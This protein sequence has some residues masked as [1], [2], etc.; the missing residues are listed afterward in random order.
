[1]V[2]LPLAW[3]VAGLSRERVVI[4][5]DF[6]QIPPIIQS[7]Q[8]AIVQTVGLDAF[9]A[10]QIEVDDQRL[11]HL[12]L[13]YR[14]DP[15]ICDLISGPMYSHRLTTAAGRDVQDCIVS[16]V[17]VPT[18]FD[19]VLTVID[20]SDLWP[21]ETQTA[22]FSR[23]NLM[24]ALLAR[25][26]AWHLREHGAISSKLDLGI[27]TPYAAQAKLIQ[28]LTQGEL[29]DNYVQVGTVHRFQGDERRMMLLDIPES[30]GGAPYPGRLIQGIPQEQE[31]AR[32]INVAVSRAQCRLF[33][34]ANLT[35]LDKKLPSGS[36]LRSI[37]FDMQEHGH[38]VSGVELLALRPIESDLAG[39][40]H[41]LP[42]EQITET[43]GIFDEAAFERAIRHDISMAKESV[44]IYS[45]YVTPSRAGQL[46]DLFRSKILE[47]VSVRCV[48][49]PP[50]TNGS[51]PR[52]LGREALDMLE[53]IGVTVDC[54]AKI[55]QKV[56]LIDNRIVWQGSL[57]ALSH[58]GRAD[59]TM[60]R[61]V[62][63]GYGAALAA[64]MSKRRMSE[65]KAAAA[66]AQAENP[67]C[68]VCGSRTIYH[69]GKHGPYYTCESECGW[70]GNQR[71]LD[72]GADWE[73]TERSSLPK[74]GPPCPLC[75]SPTRHRA[76]RY[77]PFYGCTNYPDC[78]GTIDGRSKNQPDSKR[79]RT[80][81][82]ESRRNASH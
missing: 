39:L 5:G 79:A 45:G 36:L 34:M 18:P 9:S 57:N 12:S 30:Y 28:K 67:R 63:A 32:L 37:L 58:A 1:M 14:M 11:V 81:S 60:T 56:C 73:A 8:E 20:T 71:Q 62:D 24:H 82:R 35:Y 70:K 22:F 65:G 26:L 52:E 21:F 47:G 15:L 48:T 66:I 44:V 54:R 16:G 46:G 13:Q 38:V 25:N 75:G 40:I 4:S 50:Q 68:P 72:R 74:E 19:A 27:C 55:H 77:G 78:K 59:E 41:Q 2:M 29:L 76:G 64:H 69:E 80:K 42:F 23:F 53:G 31:G 6:R 61:A 7:E 10:N 33:V 3:F 49:R 17:S 43:L 51:I